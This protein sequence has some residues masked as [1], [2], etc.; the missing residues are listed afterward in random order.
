MKALY[1]LPK[2]LLAA[3]LIGG[4]IAYIV[5]NDPPR[6]LCKTQ[7]KHFL[8][9]QKG[10][11][12]KDP[13]DKLRKK[14]LISRLT[15]SCWD[16]Y[17]PGG[18]YEY[19]SYLRKLLKD[20]FLVSQDCLGEVSQIPEARKSLFEGARI[21]TRIAWRE[22][23]LTGKVSKLNW[24]SRTDMSLFCSIKG[25]IISFYGMKAWEDFEKKL[26]TE[27][28]LKNQDQKVPPA[29]IKKA[30]ILSE[31]CLHYRF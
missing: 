30:S 14:P 25:K 17:A 18:C 21:M 9:V 15:D 8:S 5:I 27:L 4:G 20:F 2:A 29:R 19:F 28:P 12:I 7:K 6:T 24:L 16:A 11:L 26:L 13:A 31:N 23:A 10:V 1:K 22:Q 3:I